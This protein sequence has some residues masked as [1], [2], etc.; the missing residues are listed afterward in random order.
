MGL[1]V[2]TFNMKGSRRLDKQVNVWKRFVLVFD[3]ETN[4][5][6]DVDA[7]SSHFG[8]VTYFSFAV[9]R[10]AGLGVLFDRRSLQGISFLPVSDGRV[11]CF[12]FQF[13]ATAF[14]LSRFMRPRTPATAMPFFGALWCPVACIFLSNSNWF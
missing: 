13:L 3:Q 11:P 1:R 8:V 6:R 12:D 2:L 10:F 7:F 5:H 14:G 9:G 4:H